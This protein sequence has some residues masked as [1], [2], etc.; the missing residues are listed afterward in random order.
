MCFHFSFSDHQYTAKRVVLCCAACLSN[1]SFSV[2][3]TAFGLCHKQKVLALF[4]LCCPNFSS[5]IFS[6]ACA[7]GSSSMLHK[8]CN[9]LQQIAVQSSS[10]PIKTFSFASSSNL[11]GMK[12][13]FLF[14]L[15][16]LAWIY[17]LFIESDCTEK[18][19]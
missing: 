11:K 16:R 4:I 14:R 1:P 18:L 10:L 8:F 12:K 19:Y 2:H 15:K 5:F 9:V 7:T 17:R 6:F 3:T 13:S